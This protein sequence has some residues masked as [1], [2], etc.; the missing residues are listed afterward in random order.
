[1]ATFRNSAVGRCLGGESVKNTCVF[2]SWVVISSCAGCAPAPGPRMATPVLLEDEV[3][4][5]VDTEGHVLVGTDK[6]AQAKPE[7]AP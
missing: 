2:L 7:M 6:A 4:V 3:K 5:R 1:M